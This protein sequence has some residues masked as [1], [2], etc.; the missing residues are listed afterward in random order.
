MGRFTV[1]SL[2]DPEDYDQKCSTV[3]VEKKQKIHAKVRKC[4]IQTKKEREAFDSYKML[5]S[6][7]SKDYMTREELSKIEN[8]TI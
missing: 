3:E 6:A 5:L 2:F 8:G 7:K 4:F 1:S